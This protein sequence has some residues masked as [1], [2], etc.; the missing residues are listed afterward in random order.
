MKHARASDAAPKPSDC[1]GLEDT[2][3]FRFRLKRMPDGPVVYVRGVSILEACRLLGWWPAE[4]LWVVQG[5]PHR[6][7]PQYLGEAG[8]ES[9]VVLHVLEHLVKGG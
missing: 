8:W 3:C 6:Y 4:V 9:M 1:Q 7:N 2:R 5:G